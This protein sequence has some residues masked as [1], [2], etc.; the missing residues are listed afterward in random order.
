MS[1]EAEE[2]L[3]RRYEDQTQKGMIIEISQ[4]KQE[5]EKLADHPIGSGQIYRVFIR[6]GWRKEKPRRKHPVK[7]TEEVIE[8]S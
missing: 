7:A 2:E 6:H 3:L 1:F 4:I 5:Y 8:A